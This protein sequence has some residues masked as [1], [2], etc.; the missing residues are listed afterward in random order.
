MLDSQ[1]TDLTN[2]KQ[3]R[4]GAI[5]YVSEQV[6]DAD[7]VAIFTVTNGLQMVQPFTQD[8]AR[9]IAALESFGGTAQSKSFEQKDVA[10]NIESLRDFLNKS[11]GTPTTG[12]QL[13]L[14]ARQHSA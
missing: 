9:L 6:T 2:L 14:V 8:K 4:E 11:D 3:V 10:G 7:A 12:S 5:K 1:T 13:R